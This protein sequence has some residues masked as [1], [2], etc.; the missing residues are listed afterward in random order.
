MPKN[1]NTQAH[2]EVF[3]MI[4]RYQ[5]RPRSQGNELMECS[6]EGFSRVSPLRLAEIRHVRPPFNWPKESTPFAN[7][8]T[9]AQMAQDVLSDS[10]FEREASSFKEHYRRKTPSF[11]KLPNLMHAYL[12]FEPAKKMSK[13]EL[14]KFRALAEAAG[15]NPESIAQ[16]KKK[17]VK[18]PLAHG[19]MTLSDEWSWLVA[20]A[21]VVSPFGKTAA[22][23]LSASAIIEL[24]SKWIK[25]ANSPAGDPEDPSFGN[26]AWFDKRF[27]MGWM[28]LD[29]LHETPIVS[30]PLG[31]PGRM[32]ALA[33][34]VEAKSAQGWSSAEI[35]TNSFDHSNIVGTNGA[36]LIAA[37]AFE[38]FDRRVLPVIRA[39]ASD[40]SYPAEEALAAHLK[41][42]NPNAP[43]FSPREWTWLVYASASPFGAQEVAKAWIENEQEQ[44]RGDDASPDGLD[45]IIALIDKLAL[46][47]SSVALCRADAK[48]SQPAPSKSSPR[49]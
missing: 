40:H 41:S 25:E 3:D 11:E 18:N 17:A 36:A 27:P 13:E 16:A 5:M 29:Y 44:R 23:E 32:L 14:D 45:Q 12:D 7:A 46:Q 31:F 20:H 42:I 8:V 48:H 21:H 28:A 4:N 1:L 26:R 38:Y 2:K 33:Q 9:L 49:L 43:D 47:S 15:L 19:R 10:G 30:A 24:S 39:E 35:I 6:P 37:E 22:C 34:L